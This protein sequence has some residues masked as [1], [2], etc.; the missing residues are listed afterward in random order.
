MKVAG[1]DQQAATVDV[2]PVDTDH[3]CPR[4][5]PHTEPRPLPAT[6]IDDIADR[7]D[8][9]QLGHDLLRRPNRK[10][11]KKAIEVCAVLV[12]GVSPS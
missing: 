12:H 9:S 8:S 5:G 10:G 11:R 3:R 7:D 6:E 1:V 4:S 2:R